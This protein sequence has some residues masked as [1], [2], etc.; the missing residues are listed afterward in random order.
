MFRT[1]PGT[2]TE[3][4]KKYF[5]GTRIRPQMAPAVMMEREA[6]AEV[7]GSVLANGDVPA[8]HS[9]LSS[10]LARVFAHSDGVP[11]RGGSK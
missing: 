2:A 3:C 11:D 8:M 9:S 6:P 7:T 4:P 1:N 5:G 10:R